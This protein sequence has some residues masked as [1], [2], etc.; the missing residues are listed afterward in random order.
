MNIKQ[1]IF[2]IAL[3][4]CINNY[5]MAKQY[6]NLEGLPIVYDAC[7]MLPERQY[8]IAPVEHGTDF[9]FQPEEAELYYSPVPKKRSVSGCEYFNHTFGNIKQTGN[10]EGVTDSRT[11]LEQKLI[12]DKYQ[13]INNRA[14]SLIIEGLTTEQQESLKQTYLDPKKSNHEN[15]LTVRQMIKD[16]Q[17]KL[18]QEWQAK[19]QHS[20]GT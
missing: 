3:L 20:T 5:I 6:E 15:I 16:H 4:G 13:P 18:R 17:K 9:L 7:S 14:M 19:Q 1:I 8:V 11:E 12:Q 2:S 10:T